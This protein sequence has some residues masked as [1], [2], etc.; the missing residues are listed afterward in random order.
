MQ[1]KVDPNQK[2]IFDGQNVKYGSHPY[3]EEQG[4]EILS[5][6]SNLFITSYEETRGL[7]GEELKI[8]LK[9]GAQPVRQKLRQM[10]HEQMQA[11][12]EEVDKLLPKSFITP[13]ILLIG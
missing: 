10:G 7:K 12:K 5:K 2:A 13:M 1:P 9:E 4:L 6:L 8:E 3:G 11:F